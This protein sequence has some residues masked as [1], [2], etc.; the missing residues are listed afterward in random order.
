MRVHVLRSP[1]AGGRRSRKLAHQVLE[2]LGHAGH[3]LIDLT[4]DSPRSSQANL[5]TAIEGGKTDLV[6]VAGGDGLVHLAIQELARSTV[7]LALAPSG[8]GNDFASALGITAI[9]LMRIHS[10]DGFERWVGSI[11]IAGFP[12]AINAR[13]NR[14]HLP[15]GA[16]IYTVA[17][18]L[19]LPRFRRTLISLR[20]DGHRIETDSA[21]LAIGN[22]SLFGGGM[23]ACPD[24]LPT[25]GLL[26]LTSIQDV[27][28]VG[29]LRHLLGR[30]GGTA[31][32]PEV[33][34]RTATRIDL[35]SV[36][37][38]IWGDGEPIGTGPLSF[39]I[40]PGALQ[41][42]GSTV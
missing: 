26:H 30:A 5:R 18:A 13:A 2:T 23:L 25:D 7:P 3:E 20:I 36:G 24:A 42:V 10:E 32:R 9:D 4:G 34:R 40:E 14:L 17:A 22:T 1:R 37:I 8:T 19:E 38:D 33:L 39:T 31:D 6:L 41:V 15:L 35:D 16:Q 29:I 27:G 11:A 12:A 21:M 28:R